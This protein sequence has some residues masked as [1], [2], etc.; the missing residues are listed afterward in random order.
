MAVANTPLGV[1][2][3]GKQ[4]AI[5][6]LLHCAV[7]MI[8][9]QEDPFPIHM[10]V[11]SAEKLLIDVSKQTGK[12]LLIDWSLGSPPLGF[13]KLHRAT[14]NFF[15]HADNDFDQEISVP[16]I[17]RFN[18]PFLFMCTENYK[19]L[20][21]ESTDHMQLIYELVQMMTPRLFNI[22]DPETH[23]QRMEELGDATLAQFF[24]E[25]FKPNP[26]LPNLN[27]EAELD[28]IDNGGLYQT[29]IARLRELDL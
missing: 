16:E 13:F 14:Y 9:A 5:R 1:R 20:F 10:L 25:A 8:A 26:L 4:E 27:A 29:S 28:R 24:E 17:A 6:H 21:G 22:P 11:H 15:K 12:K 7:R 19:H 18:I 2:K 23:Q 3:I